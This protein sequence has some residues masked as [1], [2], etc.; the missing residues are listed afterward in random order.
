M[1]GKRAQTIIKLQADFTDI[2][3]AFGQRFLIRLVFGCCRLKGIDFTVS[4]ALV[5]YAR[6]P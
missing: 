1:L 6:V 4:R 5:G 2:T 3:R